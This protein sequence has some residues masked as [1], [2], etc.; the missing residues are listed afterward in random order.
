MANLLSNLFKFK[1]KKKPSH[2]DRDENL[3]VAETELV[4]PTNSEPSKIV[5][6]AFLQ[7]NILNSFRNKLSYMLK[8]KRY[9]NDELIQ[10]YLSNDWIFVA[11][12][13]DNAPYVVNPELSY[14]NYCQMMSELTENAYTIYRQLTSSLEFLEL[15]SERLYT[16]INYEFNLKDHFFKKIMG[17]FEKILPGFFSWEIISDEIEMQIF[18]EKKFGPSFVEIILNLFKMF[19]DKY[20]RLTSAILRDYE[21]LNGLEFSKDK[22]KIQER[23]VAYL[24]VWKDILAK[25]IAWTH[26]VEWEFVKLNKYYVQIYEHR[27]QQN[28]EFERN[29]MQSLSMLKRPKKHELILGN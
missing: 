19:P 13:T 23:W 4:D 12:R 2:P 22:Q 10:K 28:S 20:A 6:T 16:E 3:D 9:K 14:D 5:Q 25:Y 1:N 15:P 7:Q 11:K 21:I 24:N 18:H 26:E 17:D 27:L 29:L 8:E